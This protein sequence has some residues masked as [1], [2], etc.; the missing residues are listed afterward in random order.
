MKRDLFTGIKNLFLGSLAL[1]IIGCASQK[2]TVDSPVE[3]SASFSQSGSA[4]VPS[5]W[6][7]SFENNQLNALVDTALSSNFDIRTAWQRLQAS[8]AVVDRETGGL[9][10]S[11]DANAEAQ[12]TRNQQSQFGSSDDFSV[13]LSSSYEIDLWGRIGSQVDAEEYRAQA[14][15]ADF[16]TAALTI[17]AEVV[18]SW[19][20]LAEAQKQLS[21]VEN[22]IET[23]QKVLDLLKNRFG[24]GQIRGVDIL[25]QQQ[26][27]ESTRE[28]KSTAEANLKVLQHELSVLLGR[29]P[30]DTL[31]IRP[32]RI[33]ELPPLPETGVPIDLVQRRP[34]VKSAFNLV[35][36]ADRDLASA[37]SNQYPRL[38][39]SASLTSSSN[40]AGN[41]FEDWATSFAGNLLTPIFRGGELSAEV[42][43][44]EAV[45][46]QRLYEYGQTILSAFQ[47]VEDALIREQ[48]QRESIARLEEQIS[49]AEKAYNQ[50]RLEYLN[51][52][53]NYLDVL[54]ALD[55]VQQLQRDL[56]TAELTLVEYRIGLYRALA[57]S[58]ETER[59][60]RN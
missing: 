39:L 18:R 45:K 24:T 60:Q 8:E 44:L 21:L 30:Q 50:L 32:D 37:I 48:K 56:L 35:K 10:P 27:L 41:L 31:N 43:R 54:T 55:E 33:P 9:F 14:T 12:T 49:L 23:N 16:Q 38:T 26:L 1:L 2:E 53:S 7:T 47:E 20:R 6:W 4:E 46:K 29:S 3:E 40:T 19:A 17:S 52:T 25:R 58:F 5:R 28:Q 15:L 34:D 57:G 42:D 22:Q 36:A 13:G 11:L 51:G 59:E